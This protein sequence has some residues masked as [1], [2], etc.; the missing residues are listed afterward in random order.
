MIST[1]SNINY[2]LNTKIKLKFQL[3]EKVVLKLPN[4][5]KNISIVIMDGPFMC[6][7]PYG[8]TGYHVMGNVIHAIH[9]TKY[10]FY[11][12]GNKY[13]SVINKGILKGRIF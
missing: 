9:E 11:Y 10:D 7:D 1:Y 2:F 8:D 4:K 12:S 3:C 6:I 5:Y 13:K